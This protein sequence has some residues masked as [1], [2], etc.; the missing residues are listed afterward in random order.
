MEAIARAGRTD[1]TFL[2]ERTL[3]SAFI[4]AGVAKVC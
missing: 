2:T 3:V 4:D 1:T